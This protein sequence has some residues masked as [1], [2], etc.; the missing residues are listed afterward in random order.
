M[1][2]SETTDCLN[3]LHDICDLVH[4]D[5]CALLSCSKF[6]E[7]DGLVE[8]LKDFSI[9]KYLREEDHHGLMFYQTCSRLK[10]T[11]GDIREQFKCSKQI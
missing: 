4:D 6:N 8:Y 1:I 7:L 9:I 3:F 10:K 5:I 11:V 2:L